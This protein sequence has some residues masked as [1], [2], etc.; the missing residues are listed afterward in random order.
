M[1]AKPK[2]DGIAE[3]LASGRAPGVVV[4]GNGVRV[5]DQNRVVIDP[6]LEARGRNALEFERDANRIVAKRIKAAKVA[7]ERAGLSRKK[8]A[9]LRYVGSMPLAQYGALRR[10]VGHEAVHHD[11]QLWKDAGRLVDD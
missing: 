9:G 7:R 2:R 11:K 4:R 1:D 6:K 5:S 3:I 10:E 8:D